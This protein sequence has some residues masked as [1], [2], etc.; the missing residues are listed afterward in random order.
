MIQDSASACVLSKI[1]IS[2]Q[3][4]KTA[5]KI[6]SSFLKKLPLNVSS[7]ML[8]SRH[9]S[10]VTRKS[11]ISQAREPSLSMNM[12]RLSST[13]YRVRSQ[14]ALNN[15]RCQSDVIVSVSS[16]VGWPDTVT[17]IMIARPF[18]LS[19]FMS[20]TGLSFSM[21][22]SIGGGFLM[23]SG[24][25]SSGNFSSS[26]SFIFV[27]FVFFFYLKIL[28]YLLYIIL[29]PIAR[30]NARF[31]PQCSQLGLFSFWSC[32]YWY[33]HLTRCFR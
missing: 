9:R 15:D 1:A 33:S 6:Q 7:S 32:L 28:D 25:S 10:C 31:P 21:F 24:N 30:T 12:A 26:F 23:Y 17:N 22:M 8:T 11:L 20:S 3:N 13:M 2:Q 4:K 29:P 27:R 5:N 19:F 14:L 16:R 18:L